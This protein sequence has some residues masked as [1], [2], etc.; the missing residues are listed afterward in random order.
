MGAVAYSLNL[1]LP[2]P[3]LGFLL[4]FSSLTLALGFLVFAFTAIDSPSFDCCRLVPAG[5]SSTIS[6]GTCELESTRSK[7]GFRDPLASLRAVLTRLPSRSSA[8]ASEGW[9]RCE[10]SFASGCYPPPEGPI[11]TSALCR[12]SPSNRPRWQT[13]Q[14]S[15]CR[16]RLQ[17]A[18]SSKKF[19]VDLPPNHLGPG[20]RKRAGGAA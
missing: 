18:G 3:P 2:A 12:H 19:V 17:S 6:S 1:I 7:A 14:L 8:K 13:D 10:T 16:S 20:W 11:R 9:R 4:G 5:Q 15:R